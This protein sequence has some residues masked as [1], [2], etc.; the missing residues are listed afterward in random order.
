MKKSFQKIIIFLL[1][2]LAVGILFVL[3]F[4][5]ATSAKSKSFQIDDTI[6]KVFLGDS[7]VR[8]AVNDIMLPNSINLGNSSESVYFSYYKLKQLL[9]S[10]PA[11]ETVNL[12]FSYHNISDYYDQFIYGQYAQSVAANYFYILSFT[13]QLQMI[14]WNI[15]KLPS[16]VVAILKSGIKIW[17]NENTFEGGFDNPYTNTAANKAIMDERLNFQY[18]TNGTLN[19]FSDLNMNYFGKI[20][21][22]CNEFNVKLVILNTPMHSYYKS[23]VPQ[24]FIDKYNLILSSDNLRS[25]D[26]SILEMPDNCF[27]EDGDLVSLEGSVRVTEEIK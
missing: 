26:L 17:R 22:L 27:Q 19:S 23:K 18:Y 9:K 12:G 8:Y 21:E 20:V 13:E 6:T 11:I 24:K 25:F 1:S 16:F 5:L 3:L 15:R 10:N 7:H 2:I 14:K 4:L